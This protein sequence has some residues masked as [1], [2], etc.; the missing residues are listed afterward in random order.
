VLLPRNAGPPFDGG[1]DRAQAG[2]MLD[3]L[4]SGAHGV[5]G[6]GGGVATHV[7]RDNR[8]EALELASRGLVSWVARQA[9]IARQS[10]VWMAREA[11][12]QCRRVALRPLQPQCQ[13]P[14]SA[15]REKRSRAPGVAPASSRA[16]RSAASRFA[17]RTETTPLSRSECPPM[18]FV[19]DC[20][21]TSAP[22]ASGR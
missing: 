14:G 7:E 5:G 22:S 19:A 20:M 8:A 15:D 2:G 13:R 9:G 6:G 1:L 16:C 18:N 12:G 10:D 17:S 3:E 21:A 4:H 11:L